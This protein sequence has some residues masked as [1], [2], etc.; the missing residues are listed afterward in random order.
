METTAQ[1]ERYVAIYEQ[2]R[3][4]YR[5]RVNNTSLM[6]LAGQL[7]TADTPL[8]MN[9]LIALN[10]TIKKES[11]QF[12]YI[13]SADLRLL[14]SGMLLSKFNNPEQAF[15]EMMAVYE[16][17]I[18]VGYSR[19]PHAYIA[20]YALYASLEEYTDEEMDRHVARA[21]SMYTGMKK[22]HFFLTSHED[23]PL[24]ILLAEEEGEEEELL[25]DMAYYYDQLHIVLAKG[26][27]RQFL[28]QILT[29]GRQDN[30]QLLVQNTVTWLDDLKTRK[31]KLR[32]NHLPIVGVLALA[33]T[34]SAL[35]GEVKEVYDELISMKN[36]KW[37]KDICFM[38]AVRFVL[39]TKVEENNV[40]D[41]G[42]ASTI[43]SIL[44]A[45]QAAVLAAVSAGAA[46]T[47]SSSNN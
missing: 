7:V 24:S 33:G 34:P 45:Q 30:R 42:L 31:I 6:M 15:E 14:I 8:E 3:K 16:K 10:D 37:H 36:F 46:A 44:Q 29:Y 4:K 19:S 20:A 1:I 23:Y 11:S 35:I 40:L 28:S 38:T 17:L 43:E 41:V 12:A 13:Q 5:W 27:N 22:Q 18:E 26:N 25:D 9:K 39:Q 21:K 2:L 32:G 47:A